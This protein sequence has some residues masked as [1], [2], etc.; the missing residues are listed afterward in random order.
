MAIKRQ[1]NKSKIKFNQHTQNKN[2]RTPP[3]YPISFSQRLQRINSIIF[4]PKHPFISLITKLSSYSI[5]AKEGIHHHH[6]LI[7]TSTSPCSH[8]HILSP[9]PPH[10]HPTPPPVQALGASIAARGVMCAP[11]SPVRVWGEGGLAMELSI[12]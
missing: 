7:T 1:Q 11:H 12:Y 5:I 3:Q 9:R 10:V 4:N 6:I 8:H 2:K